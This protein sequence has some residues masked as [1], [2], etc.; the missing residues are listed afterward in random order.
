MKEN[1]NKILRLLARRTNN[2][3][4]FW[5]EF[6]EAYDVKCLICYAILDPYDLDEHGMVHL[7][8]HNLL[9]LI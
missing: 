7:K 5:T 1:L 4:I 9:S 2:E 8:E 3:H 6:T